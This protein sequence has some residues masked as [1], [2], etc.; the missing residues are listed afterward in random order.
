[1]RGKVLWAICLVVVGVAAA[2]FILG[3]GGDT[4]VS[5]DVASP[6][7]TVTGAPE[8][9][10]DTTTSPQAV[11]ESPVK[12]IPTP[13][14]ITPDPGQ[15][16]NPTVEEQ[17]LGG[18]A[19]VVVTF[20]LYDPSSSTLTVAGYVGNAVEDGGICTLT[21]TRGTEVVSATA[22]GMADAR[23]TSCGAISIDRSSL[24]AGTWSAV[25]RYAS[26]TTSGESGAMTIEVQ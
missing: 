12:P 10:H 20:G 15:D 1:M 21:L 6:I 4:D 24:S 22:T 16:E 7:A 11:D 14:P 23:T 9:L 3:R 8:P 17:P 2:A 25:L 19:D 5:E 18:P 13:A 26:T